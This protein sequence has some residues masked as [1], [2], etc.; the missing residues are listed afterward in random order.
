M[1]VQHHKYNTTLRD[2]RTSIQETWVFLLLQMFLYGTF[3]KH[4]E[5]HLNTQKQVLVYWA[6]IACDQRLSYD[7]EKQDFHS[8][9]IKHNKVYNA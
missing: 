5:A 7:T 2:V 8:D 3:W 9:N 1:N 6:V 4:I